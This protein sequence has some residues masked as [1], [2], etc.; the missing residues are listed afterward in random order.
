M[1]VD[2]FVI[3]ER[4]RRLGYNEMT[5][6]WDKDYDFY[7]RKDKFKSAW[8]QPWLAHLIK[9]LHGRGWVVHQF[10]FTVGSRGTIPEDQW[11]GTSTSTGC[12][13]STDDAYSRT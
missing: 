11:Q 9:H 4:S 2:E 10:N 13:T 7:V 5:R 3:N 12:Q 8:Y 1:L 6:G